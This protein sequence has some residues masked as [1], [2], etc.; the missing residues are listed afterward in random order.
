MNTPVIEKFETR[1]LGPKDWGIEKLVAHTAHYTGKV[2]TMRAGTSGPFQYHREKNETF[3]L[4]SGVA[5]VTYRDGEGFVRSVEMQPG[6]SYHV[7]PGAPHQVTAVSECVFFE[8]STPHFDDRVPLVV[9]DEGTTF[10]A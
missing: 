3:Y 8:A 2:L 5:R 6:E 4:F 7:P 9:C 10:E 1:N